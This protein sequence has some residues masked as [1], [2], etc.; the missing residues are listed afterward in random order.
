MMKIWIDGLDPNSSP[1]EILYE[2]LTSLGLKSAA[3]NYLNT[4]N[5]ILK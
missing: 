1:L 4:F 5:I 3:G 2:S